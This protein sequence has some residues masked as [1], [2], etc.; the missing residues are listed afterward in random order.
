VLIC[1]G[2]G[3]MAQLVR[4]APHGLAAE[5]LAGRTPEFLTP[6]TSGAARAYRVRET[7]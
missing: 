7:R 4:D 3:S 1:T 2:G 6:V 5:L